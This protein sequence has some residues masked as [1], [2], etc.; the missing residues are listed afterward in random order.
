[1]L[2]RQTETSLFSTF[3]HSRHLFHHLFHLVKLLYKAVDF[4]DVDTRALCN[5]VLS[6]WI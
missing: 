5:A 3:H 6:G 2:K 1:M 4:T